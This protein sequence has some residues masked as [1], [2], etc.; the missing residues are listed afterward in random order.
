MRFLE[1]KI[2]KNELKICPINVAQH[3]WTDFRLNLG[4]TFNSTM[5]LI[6][7]LL[8]L[9]ENVPKPLFL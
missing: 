2:K 7:C 1:K 5:F 6:F 4:Q 8:F 3:S 9:F